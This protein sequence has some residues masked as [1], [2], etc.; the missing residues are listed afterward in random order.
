MHIIAVP[1]IMTCFTTTHNG[2]DKSADEKANS[3]LGFFQWILSWM[4]FE[5]D[6]RLHCV[7]F[8]NDCS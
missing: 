2:F 6:L 4:L 8:V 5:R 3:S 7:N 1:V